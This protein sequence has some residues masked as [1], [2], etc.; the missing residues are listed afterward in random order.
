MLTSSMC[1]SLDYHMPVAWTLKLDSDAALPGAYY[2]VSTTRWQIDAKPSVIVL[3]P[4]T[5]IR[6]MIV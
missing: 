6:I 5:A 4:V 1:R 3:T 2:L